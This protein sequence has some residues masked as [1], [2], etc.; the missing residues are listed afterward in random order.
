M[1]DLNLLLRCDMENPLYEKTVNRDSRD[2]KCDDCP[3][4]FTKL[5]DK[6]QHQK[7]VHRNM[8]GWVD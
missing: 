7:N 2:I 6:F 8:D 4:R 3:L 5:K 1:S